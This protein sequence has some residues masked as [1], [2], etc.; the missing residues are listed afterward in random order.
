MWGWVNKGRAR[1]RARGG[2][3]ERVSIFEAQRKRSIPTEGVFE[4]RGERPQPGR[5]LGERVGR[6][7]VEGSM[8]DGAGRGRRTLTV[9]S[10]LRIGS[11]T[12]K[13]GFSTCDGAVDCLL[14]YITFWLA[15]PND[16]FED[17]M[18]LRTHAG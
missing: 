4:E 3:R 8:G 9:R 16:L 15:S 7:E 14:Q 18:G 17:R 13:S 10:T 5:Y 12:V 1:A 6:L 2:E 11:G